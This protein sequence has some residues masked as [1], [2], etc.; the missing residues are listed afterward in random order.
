MDWSTVKAMLDWQQLSSRQTWRVGAEPSGVELDHQALLPSSDAGLFV[1]VNCPCLQETKI[2][3]SKNVAAAMLN[4]YLLPW[5]CLLVVGLQGQRSLCMEQA[6]P[7]LKFGILFF[8]CIILSFK[9]L[10]F[11]APTPLLNLFL[12]I[13]CLIF[14]ISHYHCQHG[15]ERHLLCWG[16]CGSCL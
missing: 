14:S 10:N 5:I 4:A 6:V 9:G 7:R 3:S 2:T 8:S 15:H 16:L 1:W 11:R 12:P 13:C